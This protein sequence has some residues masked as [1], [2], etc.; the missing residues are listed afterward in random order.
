M[1]PRERYDDLGEVIRTAVDRGISR[2]WT[3]LPVRVIEDSDGFTVKLQPLIQ[4]KRTDRNGQQSDVTMP[5]LGKV[6]VC[7]AQGG[8]FVATHPIKAGDEGIA[9]FSARCIDAWWDRGGVQPQL[10]QR[11]HNLSDA[12]YVPGVRSKPRRLGGDSGDGRMRD[13]SQST[14][15]STNSFVIRTESG[16]FYIE[17]TDEN[18]NIVAKTVTIIASEKVRIESPLIEMTGNLRVDGE[19]T[20]KAGGSGRVTLSQHRHRNVQPGSGQSGEPQAGT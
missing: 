13:G 6:P 16:Q 20:A 4:G 9:V 7:Y 17:L 12:M 10:D 19:V 1:Q 14:P 3:S 11:R 8:G 5:P 18:V 15:P 2:V